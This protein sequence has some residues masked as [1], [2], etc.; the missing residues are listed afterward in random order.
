MSKHQA[1]RTI[2]TEIHRLNREIDMCI[3]RG[4][5]YKRQAVR[6]KFLMAQLARLASRKTLFSFLTFAFN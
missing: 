6:H 2:R 5:S 4:L 3:I 1:V